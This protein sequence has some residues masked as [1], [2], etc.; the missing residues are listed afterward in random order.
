MGFMNKLLG[1]PNPDPKGRS[2][3]LFEKVGKQ[4]MKMLFR[5]DI[6]RALQHAAQLE[7]TICNKFN[8]HHPDVGR[9]RLL[10]AVVQTTVGQ[11][12]HALEACESSLD[13]LSNYEDEVECDLEAAKFL[14]AGLVKLCNGERPTNDEEYLISGDTPIGQWVWRLKS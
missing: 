8:S 1:Y 10:A 12:E 13:I 9:A 3:E 11:Y 6:P 5:G 2:R 14:H 4:S 7:G